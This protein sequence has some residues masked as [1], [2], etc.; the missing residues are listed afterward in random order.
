MSVQ[1]NSVTFTIG[2]PTAQQIAAITALLNGETTTTTSPKRGRPAKNTQ[3]AETVSSD[4]SEDFGTTDMTESDFETTT[5]EDETTEE[6]TPSFDTVKAAINKYGNAHPD[7]MK[8]IL[9]S[10]GV[11]S[12]KELEASPSKWQSVLTK[13]QAKLKG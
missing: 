5:T 6:E 3:P 4:E 8:A 13:V 10:F 11:K 9:L 1:N 2:N 7:K 12:T